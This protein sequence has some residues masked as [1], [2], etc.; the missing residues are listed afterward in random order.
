MASPLTR[1][2]T[3]ALAKD[4]QA[5][6]DRVKP[7]DLEASAGM[8]LRI[9]G[10]VK[11]LQIVLGEAEVK[12]L[13]IAK[14][15]LLY[16]RHGL[17]SSPA[18]ALDKRCHLKVAAVVTHASGNANIG[19]VHGPCRQ[20][21]PRTGQRDLDRVDLRAGGRDTA[22]TVHVDR[23]GHDAGARRDG[24]PRERCVGRHSSAE[25]GVSHV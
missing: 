1:S 10:A 25:I 5:L 4:L 11:A 15:Q 16:R 19:L 9:E 20:D 12:E 13:D 2:Q 6:L 23:E 17:T 14:D 3:A 21:I 18:R 8:M 7:G 24:E 22:T